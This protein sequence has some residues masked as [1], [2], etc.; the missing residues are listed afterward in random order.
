MVP[1]V[2]PLGLDAGGAI[3][4]INADTL[5]GA[6]A[7]ALGADL[8][9]FL[10]DVPGVLDAGGQLIESLTPAQAEALM[11]SGVIHGG[12][13]PKVRGCLAA[14][15]HGARAVCIADGRDREILPALL[16]GRKHAGTILQGGPR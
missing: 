11:A 5:C 12:M 8:T 4:N 15:Q 9:V 1:L 14:L 6:V 2:A 7:G 10:T 13:V 16:A 3:R